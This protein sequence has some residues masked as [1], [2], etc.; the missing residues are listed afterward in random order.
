M[1]Q[2]WKTERFPTS[3]LQVIQRSQRATSSA[4]S[5]W[6]LIPVRWELRWILFTWKWIHCPLLFQPLLGVIDR[7]VVQIWCSWKDLRDGH[8]M[9]NAE[10]WRDIQVRGQTHGVLTFRAKLCCY[11]WCSKCQISYV[12]SVNRDRNWSGKN[13]LSVCNGK[14]RIQMEY[15]THTSSGRRRQRPS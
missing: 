1:G 11:F 3:S 10:I 14:L 2:P 6:T 4:S 13:Q 5:I 7:F 12:Y 9:L 15:S 8:R